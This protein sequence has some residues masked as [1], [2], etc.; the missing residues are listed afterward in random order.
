MIVFFDT[1]KV[2]NTTVNIKPVVLI[3]FIFICISFVLSLG[4]TIL[5]AIQKSEVTSFI[6]IVTQFINLLGIIILLSVS[7]GSLITVSILVGCSTLVVNLILHGVLWKKKPYFIPKFSYY[8][9]DKL[10]QICS[11]GIKFFIIKIDALVLYT[12]DNLIIS[13]YFGAKDVTPYNTTRTAFSVVYSFFSALMVPLWSQYTVAVSQNR[14]DW[15]RRSIIKLDCLLLPIGITLGIAS[16]Y[17]KKVSY[18]WLGRELHYPSGLII[19]MAIYFL[20]NCWNQIYATVSNGM[21]FVNMQLALGVGTAIINIPL[22]VY[23]GRDL[24]MGSTGVLLATVICMFI[25]IIPLTVSVHVFLNRK[26]T[27]SSVDKFTTEQ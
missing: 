4:K 22:C 15:I 5:F 23:L 1:S 25:A 10:K 6:G 3:S 14:Y 16:I 27:E 18:I 2:F 9:K 26:I 13:H 7:K 8:R 19:C 17:W 21:G 12:T 24:G 11:V 20:L